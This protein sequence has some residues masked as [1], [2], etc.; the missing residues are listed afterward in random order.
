MM[1]DPNTPA[2]T[3]PEPETDPDRPSYALNIT[4]RRAAAQAL[5]RVAELVSDETNTQTLFEM[6][7]EQATAAA[8]AHGL[9]IG[10]WHHGRVTAEA[11]VVLFMVTVSFEEAAAGVRERWHRISKDEAD[12]YIAGAAEFL[13]A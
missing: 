7:A 3:A 10:S 8:R 5:A 13:R 12:R 1:A 6:I 2:E 4:V 9:E 11:V